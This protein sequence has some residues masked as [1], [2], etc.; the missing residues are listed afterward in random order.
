MGIIHVKVILLTRNPDKIND[1]VDILH[2]SGTDYKVE[3]D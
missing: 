3:H 2:P 1:V